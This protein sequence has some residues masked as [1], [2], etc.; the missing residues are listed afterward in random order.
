MKTII[1]GS[2]DIIKDFPIEY[3]R[4]NKW[5][6]LA[7]IKKRE[8]ELVFEAIK[9][10]GWEITEVVS[11]TARGIDKAGEFCAKRLGIP[12]K[13]MPAEWD[14]HGKSAGFKRNQQMA[15]YGEALIC[16]HNGSNGSRHMLNIAKEKGL[17]IHEV[18]LEKK[19]EKPYIDF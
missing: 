10:C 5:A 11:G 15:E 19:H 12:V 8:Q 16:I 14:L 9:N 13:K 3:F 1:A 7:Y 17:R 6:K 18:N 2:R 4:M